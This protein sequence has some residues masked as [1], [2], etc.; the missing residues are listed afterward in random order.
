MF[1]WDTITV[2]DCNSI[3]H[4]R[5]TQKMT[6]KNKNKKKYQLHIEIK[7]RK[8][9][10]ETEVLWGRPKA[11]LAEKVGRGGKQVLIWPPQNISHT[12][13]IPTK[14]KASADLT[15]AKIFL[16]KTST[17]IKYSS[18]SISWKQKYFYYLFKKFKNF[19]WQQIFLAETYIAK[20]P[21]SRTFIAS[22]MR[23]LYFCNAQLKT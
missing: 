12:N 1:S 4:T 21:F 14:A 11:A 17:S 22:R 7:K 13:N 23:I 19:F 6:V 15:S 9:R 2:V 5:V 10:F 3:N 20:T 18:K 16:M 8:Y